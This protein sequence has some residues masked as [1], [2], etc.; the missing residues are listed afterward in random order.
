[1][2]RFFSLG[3][4]GVVFLTI[5]LFCN[6]TSKNNSSENIKT[7][8][9]SNYNETVQADT[10]T[11]LY[12]SASWCGPCRSFGPIVN[13]IANEYK[14]RIQVCKI[15]VDESEDLCRVHRINSVPTIVFMVN[16]TV[17]DRTIGT[18]HKRVLEEKI[19]AILDKK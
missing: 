18:V 16:G 10:P 5:I 17:V 19:D 2:H 8:S 6:C 4:I 12:F 1:M 15:D 9:D 7:L 14:G 13:E 11:L 3:R